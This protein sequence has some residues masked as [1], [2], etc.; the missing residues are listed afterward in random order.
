M[1]F[2]AAR[3]RQVAVSISFKLSDK[4][5]I[6]LVAENVWNSKI[7]TGFRVENKVILP[8]V[9]RRV[10]VGG[11]KKLSWGRY[12]VRGEVE[13]GTFGEKIRLPEIYFWVLPPWWVIVGVS[14]LLTGGFI[15][16][17]IRY[18]NYV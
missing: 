14:L 5:K 7:K 13:Y 10:E 16:T 11:D 6:K 8:G 17:R 2:W 9:K 18:K 3:M 4:P 1:P 15:V 12:V